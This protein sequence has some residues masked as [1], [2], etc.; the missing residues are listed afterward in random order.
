MKAVLVKTSQV[1][2]DDPGPSLDPFSSY[3]L[4]CPLGETQW[5][6]WIPSDTA[7]WE[8][9][10]G[11]IVLFHLRGKIHAP[12]K[13]NYHFPLHICKTHKETTGG[14]KVA[15]VLC[16][17]ALTILRGQSSSPF[18]EWD[19]I[20]VRNLLNPTS[21]HITPLLWT[22]QNFHPTSTHC[23][24]LKRPAP[25]TSPCSFSP[26]TLVFLLFLQPATSAPS[27]GPPASDPPTPGN[28]MAPT[29]MSLRPCEALAL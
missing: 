17:Q 25:S 6:L 28:C 8:N 19:Q 10:S 22:V 20:R 15:A 29:F 21:D 14:T 16:K 12:F 9:Y 26:E 3:P 27:L 11:Y 23:P 1:E 7:E 5:R 2:E 24:G 13:W 4:R 18:C